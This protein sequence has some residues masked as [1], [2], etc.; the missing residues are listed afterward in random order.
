MTDPFDLARTFGLQ[1]TTITQ[2]PGEVDL[3]YRIDTADET[4]ILKVSRPQADPSAIAFETEVMR[5]LAA[6]ELPF[7]TPRPIEEVQPLVKGR[8]ARLQTWVPGRPLSQVKPITS[9]LRRQWGTL[10]GHLSKALA[11][12]SHPDAPTD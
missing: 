7:R 10:T 5:H 12:F 8:L 3:N 4:Y 6:K 2:L 9:E 11:D 1:P